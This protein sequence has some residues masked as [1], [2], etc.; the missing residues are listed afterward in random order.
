LRSRTL[1]RRRVARLESPACSGF[2]PA[3]RQTP[4]QSKLQPLTTNCSYECPG[5]ESNPHAFRRHPLKMVCLPIP[6]PGRIFDSESLGPFFQ[7]RRGVLAQ[8][9]RC[10]QASN[11]ELLRGGRGGWRQLGDVGRG[12]S[13][14][15]GLS[16]WSGRPRGCAGRHR[17]SHSLKGQGQGGEEEEPGTDG[18]DATEKR[19]RAAPAEGAG[20]RAAA[21]GSAHPGI[22]PRLEKNDE[23]HE[24]AEKD[25]DGSEKSQHR[26]AHP[27]ESPRPVTTPS[28]AL[29]ASTGNVRPISTYRCPLYRAAQAPG[30]ASMGVAGRPGVQGDDET[31]SGDEG[32]GGPP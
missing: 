8:R 20:S 22:L 13:A 9:S 2:V 25:V 3:Q 19:H 29:V 26:A 31:R 21:E 4:G 23:N 14:R 17:G 7:G 30:H 18:R 15:C 12:C 24:D 10:E 16:R 27:T 32:R 1:T 6:P 5:R 11:L 28:P